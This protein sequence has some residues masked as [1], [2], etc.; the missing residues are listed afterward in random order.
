[1]PEKCLIIRTMPLALQTA[2]AVT[3]LGYEPIVLPAAILKP[4]ENSVDATQIQAFL[5]TSP[6]APPLAKIEKYMLSIPVYAVGDRTAKACE[7]MGFENVISAGGDAA[8]LA[9]L[10]ADRLSVKNGALMHLRGNEISGDVKGLLSACGFEVKSV[11]VYETIEN[12]RFKRELPESLEIGQ[13]IVLFH[14]PKG[15]A[16]FR[17]ALKDI[18]LRNWRAYAISNAAAASLVDLGFKEIKIAQMPNEGALLAAI[19]PK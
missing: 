1:M 8:A 12:P 13:G 15:A 7:N 2:Q 14:S 5:V 10:V 4:T 9:V 18:D 11:T 19:A 3:D 16:R 6:N 17:E